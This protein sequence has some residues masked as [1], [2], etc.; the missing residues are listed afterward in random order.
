MSC[1]CQNRDKMNL[2]FPSQDVETDHTGYVSDTGFRV[3][4]LFVLVPECC[5][6][7]RESCAEQLQNISTCS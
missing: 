5:K 3:S 4:A 6:M 1:A 7:V 2:F